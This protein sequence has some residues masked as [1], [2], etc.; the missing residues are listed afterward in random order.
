M[1]P[2][3]QSIWII[4]QEPTVESSN[5]PQEKGS[6]EW[7][8]EGPNYQ[9]PQPAPSPSSNRFQVSAQTLQDNMTQFLAVMESIFAQAA[10]MNQGMPLDEVTLSVEVN[11]KGQVSLLGNGGELGGKGAIA[12][13]FKRREV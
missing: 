6:K 12:L 5:P 10:Q 3:D 13:K 11:G 4:S 9:Q 8:D 1:T 7:F 2:N